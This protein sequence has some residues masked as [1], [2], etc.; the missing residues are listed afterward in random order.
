MTVAAEHVLKEALGLSPVDRAELIKCLF[1]SFDPTP[2][3]RIDASWSNEI[4]SRIEAFDSG[5]V[6]ASPADEVFSRIN[7][8]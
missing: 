3:D 6:S 4:E 7:K 2:D 8:R 1:K 5:A